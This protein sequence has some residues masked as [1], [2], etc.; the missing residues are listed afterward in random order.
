MS[1]LR[2]WG[3]TSNNQQSTNQTNVPVGI[4][5]KINKLKVEIN[6]LRDNLDN[7]ENNDIELINGQLDELEL[8]LNE[9]VQELDKT[10]I[11]FKDEMKDLQENLTNLPYSNS[12]ESLQKQLNTFTQKYTTFKT[13]TD[14]KILH[15]DQLLIRKV[16]ELQDNVNGQIKEEINRVIEKFVTFKAEIKSEVLHNYQN[17]IRRIEELKNKSSHRLLILQIS[18]KVSR[19][20]ANK[21][22]VLMNHDKYYEFPFNLKLKQIKIYSSNEYKHG[23]PAKFTIHKDSRILLNAYG[24]FP[25]I[26]EIEQEMTKGQKICFTSNANI[27][28]GLYC[29]LYVEIK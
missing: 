9:H 18:S 4:L 3:Y 27:K 16:G 8:T 28:R 15:F 5:E 29:E 26:F 25:K 7:E 11:K 14:D 2:L 10:L 20:S 21:K 1:N 12:I 23:R 17:L 22:V 6:K 24:P 19:L 13:E